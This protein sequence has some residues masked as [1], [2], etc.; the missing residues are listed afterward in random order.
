MSV[1][2]KSGASSDE[3]TVDPVSKASR[4][5]LYDAAG[6]ELS[7]RMGDSYLVTGGTAAV[8]AASLAANTTLMAM[9]NTAATDVYITKLQLNFAVA[10]VGTSALVA[11]SIAWQ[12]F[13][14]AT[15][16]GGTART[17]AKKSAARDGA[18]GVT[19][20]RDSNAALTV[21]SVAFGDLLG[22]T[23]VP[24]MISGVPAAPWILDLRDSPIVVP[25][26]GGVCL[27]TQVACPAT[28]TWQYSYLVEWYE[29]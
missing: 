6:R 8:V 22:W 1:V 29:K 16:T 21:T 10:T 18:S 26:G 12:R 17:V 11:G 25:N 19:D 7:P 20:V 23:Q 5:T 3:Q 9:R 2:I 27:R 4:A 28:Q 14:T 15:P 13:N 24:L